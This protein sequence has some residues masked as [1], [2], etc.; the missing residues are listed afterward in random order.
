MSK[1]FINLLSNYKKNP[2]EKGLKKL[3]DSYENELVVEELYKENSITRKAF[4]NLPSEFI[5]FIANIFVEDLNEFPTMYFL[6]YEPLFSFFSSE[7]KENLFEK[8]L[9]IS[10]GTDANDFINGFI[11]L[12]DESSDLALFYFNRIDNYVADYFIGI[13]YQENEN[14]ENAIKSNLRFL[15]GISEIEKNKTENDLGETI[16]LGEMDSIIFPKWNVLNDIAFCYNRLQDY[17]NAIK[18]YDLSLGLINLEDNFAINYEENTETEKVDLFTIFVNNY[19]LALEKTQQFNKAIDI[20]D[21]VIRKVPNDYYYKKQKEEF[22]QKIEDIEFVDDIIKQLFKPKKAFDIGEFETTKLISKEKALED[23]ILEQIKYGFQVFNKN[24]EVYQDEN[25]YGRQYYIS[26]VNG[27][28]DL[29]L[30][31]K[32]TDQLYVVELKRNEAGIE[33]VE[34]TEKYIFGL[35]KELNRNI[36]GIICLHKPKA[37]LIKLVEEKDNIELYTYNFDFDKIA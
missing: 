16:S 8:S 24:L 11:K 34:Q 26:S 19:L 25:I 17:E 12:S 22:S 2:T 28:L 5:E 37:E 33:V 32:K 23:M 35:T 20:L 36:K 21:F 27:F 18:T 29:L 13:C 30:I 3:K 6:S 4:A 10:E 31:D 14:Y 7:V 15:N 1:T 9:S